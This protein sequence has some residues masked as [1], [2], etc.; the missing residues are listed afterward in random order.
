MSGGMEDANV[1]SVTME[2]ARSLQDSNLKAAAAYLDAKLK[3][4][5]SDNIR[6]FSK[7][8]VDTPAKAIL[9]VCRNENIDLIVITTHGRSGLGRAI[10]GSVADQVIRQAGIPVMVIRP[11]SR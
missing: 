10:V 4:L 3:D 1:T 6:V 7:A 9:D 8:V 11:K 2:N 5:R